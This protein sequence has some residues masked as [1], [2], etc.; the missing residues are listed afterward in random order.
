MKVIILFFSLFVSCFASAQEMPS[1]FSVIVIGGGPAGLS[2][3]TACA[4]MGFPTLVCDSEKRGIIYPD[5]PVTNWPGHPPLPWA[6]TIEEMQKEFIK[7]GGTFVVTH[8]RAITKNLGVFHLT[9]DTGMYRAPAIV[10]ATGKEPPRMK[11]PVNTDKPTRVLSLLF[12]DSALSPYDTAIIIG[13]CEYTL[14]TAIQAATKIKHLFVFL[15]PPWRSTGSLVE[16]TAKRLLNIT[17]VRYDRILA[18]SS[19]KEKVTIEYLYR[20]SKFV[21]DASW[22]I[23]AETWIPQSD[24]VH[25]L[26]K[27]DSNGTL[28]TY[29]RTGITPTSGLF[30]CGEVASDRF[31]P[32]I[33]AAADGLITSTAVAQFLIAHRPLPPQITAP[34]QATPSQPLPAEGAT[35]EGEMQEPGNLSPSSPS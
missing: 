34:K 10:M 7:W 4:K 13:N 18:L 30:A 3:A 16:R 12:D 28:I 33:A 22:A 29:D 6:K 9:T 14:T 27:L 23:F 31:L 5:L 15:Q 20:G 21:Q 1:S 19:R 32:G 17:W 2:C 8:V 35:A 24:L 11:F 25:N 26:A